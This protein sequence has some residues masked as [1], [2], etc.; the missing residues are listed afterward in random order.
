MPEPRGWDTASLLDKA[1]AA[2]VAA[3]NAGWVYRFSAQV[4]VYRFGPG[5]WLRKQWLSLQS[6]GLRTLTPPTSQTF[7]SITGF[8]DINHTQNSGQPFV[9]GPS[10]LPVAPPVGCINR[11]RRHRRIVS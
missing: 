9:V 11:Y 8:V 7:E 5:A 2:S 3:L 1:Q 10:S 4:P 6:L